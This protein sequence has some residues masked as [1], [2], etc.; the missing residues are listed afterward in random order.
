MEKC[1]FSSTELDDQSIKYNLPVIS[2]A[3][4]QLEPSRYEL[5]KGTEKNAPLCPYGH[6][7]KWIG[8]DKESNRYVRVT[9]SVF[10]KLIR[11]LDEEKIE[12]R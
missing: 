10:K 1:A 2:A 8:F 3:E 12:F 6:K 7:F 11:L 9:K 4:Y 5:R